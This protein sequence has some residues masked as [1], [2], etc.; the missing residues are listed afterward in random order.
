M[1]AH[2]SVDPIASSDVHPTCCMETKY[3]TPCRAQR[4]KETA[5]DS[6]HT[7]VATVHYI[8]TIYRQSQLREHTRIQSEGT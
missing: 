7:F 6:L 4:A 1:G 8:S 2:E 3:T 5:T